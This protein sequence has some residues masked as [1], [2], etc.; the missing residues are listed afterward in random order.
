MEKSVPDSPLTLFETDISSEPSVSRRFAMGT[1]AM[2]ILGLGSVAAV[3][4]LGSAEAEAAYD[5]RR[6]HYGD[7]RR[8]WRDRD[9]RRRGGDW[10]RRYCD[11]D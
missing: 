1:L 2:G 6:R 3:T 7:R 4:I 9:S 5:R 8:C 10:V 11:R